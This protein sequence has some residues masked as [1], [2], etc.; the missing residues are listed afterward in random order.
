MVIQPIKSR[1]AKGNERSRRENEAGN[2]AKC[3]LCN[4]PGTVEPVLHFRACMESCIRSRCPLYLLIVFLSFCLSFLPSS[5]IVILFHVAELTIMASM[6][7]TMEKHPSMKEFE[8]EDDEEVRTYRL[9]CF[10]EA[11]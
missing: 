7:E 10:P 2:P 1:S 5:E 6:Q 11:P 8:D 3:K 4:L 9:A